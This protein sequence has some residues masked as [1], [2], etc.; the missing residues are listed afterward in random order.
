MY[1]VSQ[2]Q[3]S[4]EIEMLAHFWLP[5]IGSAVWHGLVPDSPPVHDQIGSSKD[6]GAQQPQKRCDSSSA[7]DCVLVTIRYTA[8]QGSTNLSNDSSAAAECIEGT[9]H[10]VGS[11][12]QNLCN[13]NRIL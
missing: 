12:L 3:A 6:S 8:Q 2:R 13:Y 10:T 9:Y 7:C 5:R 4:T 11:V 1:I